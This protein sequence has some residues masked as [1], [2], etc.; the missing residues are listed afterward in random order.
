MFSFNTRTL[1]Y[2][3]GQMLTFIIAPS[4]DVVCSV[5]ETI[6]TLKILLEP[7]LRNT[8]SGPLTSRVLKPGNR[9]RR[10]LL[11]VG[12]VVIVVLVTAYR[13]EI[14][15]V[16]FSSCLSEV[17]VVLIN[18]SEIGHLFCLFKLQRPR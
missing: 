12:E 5:S 11:L 13:Q 14:I 1:V 6:V 10:A 18:F 8:S 2:Q 17:V 7:D 15:P 3:A 9:K 16:C 4:T